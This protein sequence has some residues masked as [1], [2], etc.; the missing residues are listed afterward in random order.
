[1]IVSLIVAM[2][3]NRGI[4]QGG[5]IPWHLATD[6][7][8]FKR[9]TMGHHMIIGR[10]TFE[11]IGKPLPGREMIVITRQADYSASHCTVVGSLEEGLTLAREQGEAECFI[12][13]GGEIY[14]LA[15]PLA[16]RLY[17]TQVHTQINADTFFPPFDWN[18]WQELDHQ[19][20]TSGEK[21]DYAFTYSILERI[22]EDKFGL[23]S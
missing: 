5:V 6:M 1:M 12:A 10:K 23:Q 14:R 18:D 21:D 2:D 20:Y 22:Q 15:L 17:L 4:G 7:K 11:S 9:T 16:N 19:E 3:M 8:L 13:G